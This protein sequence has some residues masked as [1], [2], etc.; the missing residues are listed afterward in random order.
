MAETLHRSS[1]VANFD[2]YPA[3]PPLPS[4]SS[5]PLLPS[6]EV[7]SET[8]LEQRARQVGAALGKTVAGVRRAQDKVRNIASST[9]DTGPNL[10]ETAKNKTRDAVA[11]ISDLADS[12]R[13]K[14]QEWGEAAVS[15]ADQL[16]QTTQRKAAELG[17]QVKT[18]YYR[19]RI[20]ANQMTRDYPLHVVL[21]AGILGFLLGVGLRIW[22]SNREY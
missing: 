13:S 19:A 15:Q 3:E 7:K 9:T 11:R 1:D 2:T 16:R 17:S 22:R 8:A 5:E 6:A 21:G 4:A 20:R 10:T 18:G 12:A 14:A